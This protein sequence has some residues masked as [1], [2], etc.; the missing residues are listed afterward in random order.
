[1]IYVAGTVAIAL[2]GNYV[3][4]LLW[5]VTAPLFSFLGYLDSDTVIVYLSSYFF[6]VLYRQWAAKR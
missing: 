5:A 4:A 3:L 6:V 2:S 1:M